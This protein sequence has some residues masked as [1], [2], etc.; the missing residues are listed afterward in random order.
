MES[1]IETLYINLNRP[2]APESPELEK[3]REEYF[4]MCEILKEQYGREFVDRMFALRRRIEGH[5]GEEE[6][7]FGFQACARLML[8]VLGPD[9]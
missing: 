1:I 6:F 7:S 3:D 8:E 5:H 2:Q 9:L 4:K